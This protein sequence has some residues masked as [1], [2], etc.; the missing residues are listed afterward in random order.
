MSEIRKTEKRLILLNGS[1]CPVG[2]ARLFGGIFN[3]KHQSTGAKHSLHFF[4]RLLRVFHRA[5]HE[6]TPDHVKRVVRSG[7]EFLGQSQVG[8]VF[9]LWGAVKKFLHGIDAQD[10]A[11]NQLRKLHGKSSRAATKVQKPFLSAVQMRGQV[12]KYFAFLHGGNFFDV[13][14]S[15][16]DHRA[17]AVISHTILPIAFGRERREE[18]GEK[19]SDSEVHKNLH[20][21]GRETSLPRRSW[22]CYGLFVLVLALLG[23]PK[24]FAATVY[25]SDTGGSVSCGADGTQ[26]TVLPSGVTWTAGNTYQLCGTFSTHTVTVGASGSTGNMIHIRFE[27]NAK[28]SAANWGNVIILN[29]TN[30]DWIDIDCGGTGNADAQPTSTFVA[31]GFFEN[32]NVNSTN[33]P[34]VGT[35]AIQ[36]LPTNNSIVRNCLIQNL[37]VKT[38]QDGNGDGDGVH[39]AG[40]NNL[41]TNNVVT[42]LKQGLTNDCTSAGANN[43]VISHNLAY[44]VNWGFLSSDRNDGT[45]SCDN[46]QI[47]NNVAH[48]FANWDDLSVTT[49]NFHHN[50]VFISITANGSIMT[51]LKIYN[52]YFYGD[53]GQKSTS[54]PGIFLDNENTTVGYSGVVMFNNLM[55]DSST[56]N[57]PSNG[58]ITSKSLGGN[59]S[60]FIYNNTFIYQS[61]QKGRCYMDQ[62]ATAT[63][64]DNISAQCGIWIFNSS[65]TTAATDYNDVFQSSASDVSEGAHSITADPLLNGTYNLNTGSPAISTALNL[66][67]LGI[68][69]L[70]FDKANVARPP[71]LPWCMGV[72]QFASSFLPA[73]PFPC[74]ACMAS[75]KNPFGGTR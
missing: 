49:N 52:N 54:G 39:L 64:K 33:N 73:P 70:D 45:T 31:N 27:N 60:I 35:T 53:P 50:A 41:I 36:A 28:F 9:S 18:A 44:N 74:N 1:K 21:W 61:A 17:L 4:N 30:R 23:S 16:I 71:S 48:D 15:K 63:L 72:Y 13:L 7:N 11:V 59:P 5:H 66:T 22:L 68:S 57:Q 58:L 2:A 6:T 25:V 29:F 42:Q 34:T 10:F 56:V 62:G 75:L 65:G 8:N 69:L 47:F 46:T 55:V 51:N 37:Y 24:S 14:M 26:S 32:T 19:F 20:F 3:Q 43:S 38:L 40:A 12:R 67:S